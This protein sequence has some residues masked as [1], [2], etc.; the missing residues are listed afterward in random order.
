[1]STSRHLSRII[2]LQALFAS[3]FGRQD[4]AST[5]DYICKEFKEK[6]N[7]FSFAKMI[8]EGVRDNE[9]EIHEKIRHYAPEWPIE[10]IAKIDK[11]ILEIAVYEMTGKGDVP[12]VVALDE[13]IELA[14]S[15][16]NSNT[17]KFINGV[18]NALLNDTGSKR[19]APAA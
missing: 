1:M 9:N 12:A 10:K 3:E 4:D 8:Y 19:E 2:A 6:T 5:F 11:V 18:L 13:A 16:G 14:K 7:D 17:P 15:Y